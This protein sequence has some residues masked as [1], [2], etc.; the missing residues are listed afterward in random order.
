VRTFFSKIIFAGSS[1][2]IL[3]QES[4]TLPNKQDTSCDDSCKSFREVLDA[5]ARQFRTLRGAQIEE[6]RWQAKVIIP[7]LSA[8]VCEVAELAPPAQGMKRWGTYYCQLPPSARET[9]NREFASVLPSLKA[10]LPKEWHTEQFEND[11]EKTQIFRAGPSADEL[12]VLLACV[13][14]DHGNSLMFQASSMP[15]PTD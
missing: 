14:D 12:Y 8:G 13:S 4:P 7:A 15:I 10:S 6:N 2:A 3:A 1:L 9:A 5:R 11:D